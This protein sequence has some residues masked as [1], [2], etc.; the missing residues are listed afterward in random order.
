MSDLTGEMCENKDR[1]EISHPETALRHKKQHHLKWETGKSNFLCYL[2][3]NI[4][5]CPIQFCD[6]V[7]WLWKLVVDTDLSVVD[8]RTHKC[9]E[10]IVCEQTCVTTRVC[11]LLEK[12]LASIRNWILGSELEY[13]SAFEAGVVVAWQVLG[14]IL[15]Y[16]VLKG[17][18]KDPFQGLVIKSMLSNFF[19]SMLSKVFSLLKS[20]C[21]LKLSTDHVTLLSVFSHI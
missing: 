10:T 8:K 14:R 15:G 12:G 16:C 20:Y 21:A 7:V 17:H 11:F 13:T 18:Y 1:H 5:W 19:V 9:W 6:N 3:W 2:I 4:L